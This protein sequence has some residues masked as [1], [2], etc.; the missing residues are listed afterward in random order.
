MRLLLIRHGQTPANVAGAL[1]TVLPGPGLTELGAQQARSIPQ[2]VADEPVEAIYVSQALRTHLTARPLADHLGLEPV[3]L[4]GTHEVQAG[5]VEKRTDEESIRTYLRCMAQW[6]DSDLDVT[7]PGG[8]RGTDFFARY[9]SSVQQVFDAGH[10]VAAIVS[11]G[12]AI[13]TWTTLRSSNLGPRFALN[14]PLANTGVVVVDGEPGAWV[15]RSWMGVPLDHDED[16]PFD[17]RAVEH[18]QT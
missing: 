3:E 1:D 17:G 5:S 6:A 9:D 11:H 7:I 10:Q 12:A 16:N 4:A 18:A 14:N 15:A 13:R 8:E 2:T